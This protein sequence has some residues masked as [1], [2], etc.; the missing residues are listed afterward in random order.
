MDGGHALGTKQNSPKDLKE[1]DL[2]GMSAH[3]LNNG[4]HI[5]IAMAS[6]GSFD[7]A[8]FRSLRRT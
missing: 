5:P 7:K 3:R 8:P 1:S 4:G 2:S 6:G